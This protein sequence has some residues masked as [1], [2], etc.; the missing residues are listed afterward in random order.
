[1]QLINNT[2]DNVVKQL[3]FYLNEFYFNDSGA[4][5]LELAVKNIKDLGTFY[6]I[7]SKFEESLRTNK[8][9]T[10]TKFNEVLNHWISYFSE[11]KHLDFTEE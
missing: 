9:I 7:T 4:D 5:Y 6:Y 2:S 8:K 10:D 1:M 3:L 11:Y